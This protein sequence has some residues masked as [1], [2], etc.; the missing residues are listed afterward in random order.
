MLPASGNLTPSLRGFVDSLDKAMGFKPSAFFSSYVC[1]G[2][3]T[4]STMGVAQEKLILLP[5]SSPFP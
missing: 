4:N 1:K 2:T 5:S 3:L